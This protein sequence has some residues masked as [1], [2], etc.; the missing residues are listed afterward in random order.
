MND[1][2]RT[3]LAVLI[4]GVAFSIIPGNAYAATKTLAIPYVSQVP[5]G[6]WVLPWSE[7]CE[8]ASI[9]MVRGF[10]EGQATLT[11]A[12]T[13]AAMLEMVAWEDA[14]LK[15]NTDTTAEETLQLIQEK[16]GFSAEIEQH[17]TIDGLRGELAA[18]RPVI[19][20][21]DM[22]ALYGTRPEGDSFHVAVLTG[23]DEAADTFT[24]VDPAKSGTQT[25]PSAWLMASLHDF[26][27]ASGEADG[28]AT[29]LFTRKAAEAPG[30]VGA[31]RRLLG[32]LVE[33]FR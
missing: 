32:W 14:T 15:K 30:K 2:F 17:P 19:I 7:A 3:V 18:G 21:I 28:E 6:A 31:L 29:V 1:P 25:Y 27:P 11:P 23:Y 9:L 10:Y 13:K 8:E 20:L 4:F 12:A 33:L 22:Y 26:N 16:G 5:D 24:V